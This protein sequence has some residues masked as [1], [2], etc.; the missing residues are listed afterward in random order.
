MTKHCMPPNTHAEIVASHTHTHTL[1]ISK[2]PIL[3]LSGWIWQGYSQQ[4]AVGGWYRPQH[5]GSSAGK[6]HVQTWQGMHVY[7]ILWHYMQLLV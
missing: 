6:A 7:V 2:H 5:R 1:V 4:D 3:T